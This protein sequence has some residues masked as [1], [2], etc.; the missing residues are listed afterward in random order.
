MFFWDLITM[1][2]RNLW[3][4]K[5]RSILTIIAV[6][7]GSTAVVSMLVLAFG[8]RN[9]FLSQLEASGMLNRI[10]I[11]SDPNAEV[12]PFGGGDMSSGEG[13]KLTD[14]ILDDIAGRPHVLAA[15]PVLN[16]HPFQTITLEGGNGKRYR[17]N[18]TGI[19][20]DPEFDMDLVAGRNLTDDEK[21]M[22]KIVLGHS[23]LS[24]FGIE[25]AEELIGKNVIF[26]TYEGF[27]GIDIPLP[28]QDAPKEEWE[29]V[30]EISAEVIGVTM[31]G[32]NEGEHRITVAWAR[33][34][35]T[36]H[37]YGPPTEEAQARADELNNQKREQAE[38]ERRELREDEW[39]Q[40]EPSIE[41]QD[42]VVENGYD[43][44]WAQVDNADVVADLA[45]AIESDLAVGA[46]TAQEF[47]DQILSVF[48]VISIV[49]AAIG[50][51]ALLVAAVG[52]VNTMV[53]S[54]MERTKEIGIMKSVGATNANV[55][56]IFTF[57]AGLL[58]FWGGV[59]G[60]GAGYGLT[61]IA[62][63][64]ANRALSAEGFATQKIAELPLWL[65]L[66]VIGFTTLVG[67]LAGLY[68]AA[69]AARLNPIDALR[70]E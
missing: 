1:G 4:R 22:G 9:V 65:A 51:I 42:D 15:T 55:W 21:D 58:G 70:R 36:Q 24:T 62:N 6:L 17:T 40:P 43:S 31:P 18:V 19:R 48:T 60:I 54:V 63:I 3:R 57:E 5:L 26:T 28:P 37:W 29:K 30:Q 23:I 49:L 32:P 8:V 64:F 53:M 35:R 7:I 38:R 68:P 52:I 27:R 13:T 50:G 39:V 47:L 11:I 33:R 46:I 45:A 69:R 44:I 10:T 20:P 61:L 34:L 16:A 25:N 59:A 2:V 66:S 67:I 56:A 41:I 12:D 14:D